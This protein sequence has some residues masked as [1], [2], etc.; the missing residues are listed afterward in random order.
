MINIEYFALSATNIMFFVQGE[1]SPAMIKD[2][3]AKWVILGHSERRTIF[4][5][6]DELV[7]EKVL[8]ITLILSY[9]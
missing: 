8:N 6:K 2:I 3:G 4:A 7:A 5:E 9:H 1:I